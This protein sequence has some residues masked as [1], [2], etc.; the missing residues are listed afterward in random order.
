M[1]LSRSVTVALLAVAVLVTAGTGFAAFASNAYLNGTAR[2]GMVGPLVWGPDPT[3]TSFAPNDVC[4]VVRSMTT[5]PGDTLELT[6]SNLAPGDVCAYGD[7]LA[8]GGSLPAT[9]S[10]QITW[11]EGALCA[12][13][14]YG[15]SFFSPSVVIANGGQTSLLSHVI[16][17]GGSIQWA[18]FLSLSPGAGPAYQDASCNFVVTITGAAGT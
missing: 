13:L 2:A 10:E 17:A 16:P 8:N 11:A 5:L 4:S 7:Y 6:A 14:S 12:V 18:G 9:A 1:R 3:P 15:D